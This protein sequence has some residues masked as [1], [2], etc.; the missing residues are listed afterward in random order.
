MTIDIIAKSQ[1]GDNSATL[2]LV[3]KFNP[4]LKKYSRMLYYE[5][6]YND[7]LLNFLELIKSIEIDHIHCDND[8]IIVSYIAKS[9][10]HSYIKRLINLKHH[11]AIILYSE[12]SEEKLFNI[13]SACS[14]SDK[15]SEYDFSSMN[16]VL[17][18]YE[19]SIITSI[20]FKGYTAAEAAHSYGVSRQSINQTKLRA[21]KKL[22]KIYSDKPYEVSQ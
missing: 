14:T 12:L 15:Y 4:L 3:D 7:L 1:E 11:Q 17:T 13:E 2:F 18:E 19:M 21:L 9:I 20:F 8:A 16:K 6:A 10:H 22:R 5:D